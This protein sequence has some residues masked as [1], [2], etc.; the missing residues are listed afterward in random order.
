MRA[1][2]F[3]K[4]AIKQFNAR[5][6]MEGGN[7]RLPSGDEAGQIDL[8]VHDRKFIVPVLNNVLSNINNSF[9]KS[10][11]TSLWLPELLQNRK[12]LSGS[13][14]HFFD[15]D[16]PDEEFVRVKPLIG[17]ID[18]QVD[19]DLRDQLTGW[20]DSAKGKAIGPATLLGYEVGNEQYSSLWQ[21]TNPPIKVQIDLEFVDY[22]KGEPTSWSQFSHSSSWD[23]LGAGIKGVF[24]KY[25]MRAF[26][27]NTLKQRYIMTK[28]GKIQAKPVTSTDIA[29]AVSSGKGGGM[30]QKYEPVMDTDNGQQLEKDGI[31]VFKEI[32]VDQSKYVNEIDSMFEMIFGRPPKGDDARKLWSFT[33]GVDLANKYLDDNAKDKLANGFILTLF[34]PQGQGLYRGN[35][36]RD[37]KE[38]MIALDYLMKNLGVPDSII[39]DAEVQADNYYSKYKT[40]ALAESDVIATPRVGLAHLQ[41]MN[42]MDF[43]NFVREMKTELKGKLNDVQLDLK[44]DGLGARFGKDANGRPFFESSHSGPIFQGGMFSRHAESKGFTGEKL[45]RARHYD[46]IFH[47]V[48]NSQFVEELPPDTKVECE[49]LY[50]PLAEITETG[51]KF[52]TVSYDKRALGKLMSIVP[53]QVSVASNGDPHPKEDSIL[54][55]LM[56]HSTSTVKF[57][58]RR[59][60]QNGEI[61]VNAI[62]DPVMSIN[63]Q[64]LAILS[65]RKAADREE[66]TQ[67]KTF[68]QT[69]KDELAN[70]I[71]THPNILG[72]DMLGK[73]VE[74]IVIK[75]KTGVP[76]KV[77]TPEFKAAMAAKKQN[78]QNIA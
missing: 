33:G 56:G 61:D 52:V 51:L 17:D 11:G 8:K 18:T 78:A 65:S 31:P 25:L 28:T 40:E 63:D 57:I 19:K 47:A 58:N 22:D 50:N 74:G 29:F 67:L 23:D 77:T 75:P 69:V 59:L 16:I 54:S 12:F 34:G 72:K 37:K 38:K 5:Q 35:P 15:T 70:F 27:T 46:S 49:I 44:V 9:S 4:E 66:K 42:D 48:V 55:M 39:K 1:K 73:D 2:E 21:L 60:T 68:L 26:T 76:F 45:E 30:R 14:L 3:L 71:I 20:L 62:I 43:I 36:E 7:L 32:P 10:S 64:S 24:H 53:F 41:K 6:L 13:S